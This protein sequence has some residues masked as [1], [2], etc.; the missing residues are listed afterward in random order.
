MMAIW[1]LY[2]ECDSEPTFSGYA[3]SKKKAIEWM[4]NTVKLDYADVDDKNTDID[5]DDNGLQITV[6]DSHYI[7]AIK[8]D[9][10]D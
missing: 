5:E 6:S 9:R 3:T 10:V 2:T 7:F 1:V 8:L 4:K